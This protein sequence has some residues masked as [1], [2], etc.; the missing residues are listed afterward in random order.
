MGRK[1][2]GVQRVTVTLHPDQ[3]RWLE[4]ESERRHAPIS[5]VVRDLISGHM[6]GDDEPSLPP[7][8]RSGVDGTGRRDDD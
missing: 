1:P 3:I 4:S 5:Q 7:D 8:N 6:G 2:L